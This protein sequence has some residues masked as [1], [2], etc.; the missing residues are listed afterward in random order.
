MGERDIPL[1]GEI[2]DH[3]ALDLRVSGIDNDFFFDY[4]AFL[5]KL[6]IY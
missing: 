1:S 4:L 2:K 3:H 5:E 6:T